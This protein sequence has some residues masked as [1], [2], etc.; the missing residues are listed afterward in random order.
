M[1]IRVKVCC[2]QSIAEAEL[3]RA[4]GA[5][6]IGLVSV[7]PSGPGPIPEAEI[8]EIAAA[9]AGRIETV[10]LT[11]L[12]APADIAAQH[13]RC[14]C[15]TI[16]LCAPL[17]PAALAALRSRLPRT[18]LM[19]VIHVVGREALERARDFAPHADALLLDSGSLGAGTRELGGTGRTHDWALSRR[20]V[21]SVAVPVFLAGGLNPENV[22][23][24][25]AAVKP[26]GVDVCSGIRIEG[27]LDEA[28]L[29]A[30]IDRIEPT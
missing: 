7:M 13:A 1:E 17:S 8:A 16:Q 12:E 3:A 20:I 6:A 10:L 14:G 22:A 25:I 15:D 24:A 9:V 4:A 19:P 28:L 30:F 29:A 11:S 21:A 26:H 27:R 23:A 18:R 2:V 5:D